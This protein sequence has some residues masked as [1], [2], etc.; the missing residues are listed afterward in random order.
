MH[1]KQ[2]PTSP[3]NALIQSESYIMILINQHTQ[4]YSSNKFYLYNVENDSPNYSVHIWMYA[5][6]NYGHMGLPHVMLVWYGQGWEKMVYQAYPDST[7]G[8][9]LYDLRSVLICEWSGAS[10]KRVTL[11]PN[12]PG[13]MLVVCIT[14]IT[15][16]DLVKER[17]GQLL[18]AP[19]RK[20]WLRNLAKARQLQ[21]YIGQIS[22]R[23][24]THQL[25]I[26]VTNF[27]SDS[28]S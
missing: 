18:C 26:L 1:G 25:T 27:D 13:S 12:I 5:N 9:L 23:E 24:S 20:N 3:K 14:W 7:F 19:A 28:T 10:Y 15:S 22:N 8:L 11:D 16:V 6:L 2:W 17:A 4:R 21:S